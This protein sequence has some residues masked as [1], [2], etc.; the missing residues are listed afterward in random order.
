MHSFY[1]DQRYHALRVKTVGGFAREIQSQAQLKV[2]DI[3]K[4]FD[5]TPIDTLAIWDTGATNS[6]ISESFCAKLGTKPI[7]RTKIQG[8]NNVEERPIHL[9]DIILP[10]KVNFQQVRVAVA[11]KISSI[12]DDFGLLIGMDIISVGDFCLTSYM[13]E[14]KNPCTLFS[15]RIPHGPDPIDFCEEIN[16]FNE[17]IAFHKRMKTQRSQP[18]RDKHHRS[19]R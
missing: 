14:N 4:E 11:P 15:F 6:M 1:K 7:S 10:G 2:P 9:V 19:K 13:D 17:E 12:S 8:I 3:Y 5:R 18:K 16:K